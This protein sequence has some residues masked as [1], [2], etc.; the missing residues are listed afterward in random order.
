MGQV[1][2]NP[3]GLF[4]M[5]GKDVRLPSNIDASKQARQQWPNIEQECEHIQNERL[6]FR[7]Q[8]KPNEKKIGCGFRSKES[9]VDWNCFDE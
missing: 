9:K 5:G 1:R 2:T 7:V 3:Y 4:E 8:T 6:K